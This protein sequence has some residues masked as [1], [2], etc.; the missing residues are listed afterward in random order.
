VGAEDSQ[1]TR[2]Q[3][4]NARLTG[5]RAVADLP[6]INGYRLQFV[7]TNLESQ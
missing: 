2:W 5:G 4:E 1:H 7:L 6:A 3:Y